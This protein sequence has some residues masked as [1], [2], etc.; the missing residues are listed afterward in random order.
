MQS[1]GFKPLSLSYVMC[2]FYIMFFFVENCVFSHQIPKN[3]DFRNP[4][5]L[6]KEEEYEKAMEVFLG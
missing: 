2:D 3:H 5:F 4:F 6:R 1:E